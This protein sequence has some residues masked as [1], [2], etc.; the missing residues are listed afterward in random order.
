MDH[1]CCLLTAVALTICVQSPLGKHLDMYIV[2]SYKG[3]GENVCRLWH[4]DM[5]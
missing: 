2:W 5:L 3:M 1:N 4:S